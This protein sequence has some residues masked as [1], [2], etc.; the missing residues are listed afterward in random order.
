MPAMRLSTIAMFPTKVNSRVKNSRHHNIFRT[1]LI[2][3]LIMIGVGI[4]SFD[5]HT[6][7]TI[8]NTLY[9]IVHTIGM[10]IL[11]IH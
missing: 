6:L 4:L 9:I 1:P 10:I 11:G 2:I 8:A 5:A 3:K 7:S